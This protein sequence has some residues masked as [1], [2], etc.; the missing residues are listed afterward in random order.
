MIYSLYKVT[1]PDGRGYIGCTSRSIEQRWAEHR[2]YR[3][4]PNHPIRALGH[5]IAR[6]GKDAFIVE[7]IASAY[8][9]ENGVSTEAALIAQHGTLYPHGYNL[10]PGGPMRGSRGVL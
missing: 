10:L 4:Y 2:P 6:Y 5:G 7:H 1:G 3:L 8:G 9:V